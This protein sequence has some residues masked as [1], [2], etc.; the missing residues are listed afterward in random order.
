MIVKKLERSKFQ[1]IQNKLNV[2]WDRLTFSVPGRPRGKIIICDSVGAAGNPLLKIAKV[3]HRH[4]QI[5]FKADK[6]TQVATREK[7][8]RYKLLT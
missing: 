4:D 1:I 6:K 5:G 8:W 7:S 3:I 2:K